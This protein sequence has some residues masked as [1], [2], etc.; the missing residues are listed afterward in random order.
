MPGNVIAVLIV[1]VNSARR[2][3]YSV[4]QP[5]RFWDIVVSFF[6]QLYSI[7]SNGHRA[8]EGTGVLESVSTGGRVELGNTINLRSRLRIERALYFF[9]RSL[10]PRGGGGIRGDGRARTK[11]NAR[12]RRPIRYE[13]DR[14]SSRPVCRS[15][16][17]GC[18]RKSNRRRRQRRCRRR[19]ISGWLPRRSFD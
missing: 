2:Y 6:L 5:T 3:V 9:R 4:V 13:L 1:A 10:L 14:R 12:G 7:R 17:I 19:S 18:R 8:L 11:K 16:V 15:I